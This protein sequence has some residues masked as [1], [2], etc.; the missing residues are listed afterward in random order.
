MAN[1]SFKLYDDHDCRFDLSSSTR[2]FPVQKKLLDSQ[3]WPGLHRVAGPIY[4]LLLPDQSPRRF[5]V[6]DRFHW[7]DA[8]TGKLGE[9]FDLLCILRGL[10]PDNPSLSQEF[11]A[12]AGLPAPPTESAGDDSGNY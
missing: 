10:T 11:L 8:I 5:I 2:F 12:L 3:H 1:N 6:Q 7:Y 9:Y 4:H